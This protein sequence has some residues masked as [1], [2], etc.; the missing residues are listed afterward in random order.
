MNFHSFIHSKEGQSP[1]SRV[2][3][4]DQKIEGQ[5]SEKSSKRDCLHQGLTADCAV[6]VNNNPAVEG[7]CNDIMIIINT[8]NGW[9]LDNADFSDENPDIVVIPSG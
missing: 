4:Q 1:W 6:L 7:H 8:N 9:L 3:L 5:V 2:Q